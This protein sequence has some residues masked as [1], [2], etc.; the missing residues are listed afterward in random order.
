MA[1]GPF[2]IDNNG[3]A[4]LHFSFR[5]PPTANHDLNIYLTFFLGLKGCLGFRNWPRLREGGSRRRYQRRF[6]CFD[7]RS[8]GCWYRSLDPGHDGFWPRERQRGG[9]FTPG[10][11]ATATCYDVTRSHSDERSRE[12]GALSQLSRFKCNTR[13]ITCTLEPLS[14]DRAALGALNWH[15]Y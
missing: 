7:S 4:L 1:T 3:G 9:I 10:L 2:G 14:H 12:A 15:W 6:G 5:A 11:G 8:G 13:Q